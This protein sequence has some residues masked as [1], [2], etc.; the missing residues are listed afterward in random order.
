MTDP[1][2]LLVAMDR[3]RQAAA[4]EAVWAEGVALRISDPPTGPELSDAVKAMSAAVTRAGHVGM[5]IAQLEV[6]AATRRPRWSIR[7]GPLEL[8]WW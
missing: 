3:Q 6:S 7:L 2:A 1:R 5:L 4:G 8:R